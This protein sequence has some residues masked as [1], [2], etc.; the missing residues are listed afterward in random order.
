MSANEQRSV[1]VADIKDRT[2]IDE[3]MIKRLVDAFYA[4]IRRD[5]LLGP[6][7]AERIPDWD[8]HL[9]RMYAF[10]SSVALMSGRYHGQP[11]AKH[12][13]LPVD[14]RH[15][16]RWLGLFEAT[17]QEVCPP[18]AADHFIERARRIAASFE[19]GIAASEGVCLAK[20]ERYIR[21]DRPMPANHG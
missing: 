16:D 12:L 19:L 9:E 13:P 7:F 20:G 6:V 5:P 3:P 21:S 17:A 14:A 4:T 8:S 15:F 18:A 10:W 2:G 1:I 11:M